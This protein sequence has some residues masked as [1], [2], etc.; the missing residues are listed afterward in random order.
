MAELELV[1]IMACVPTWIK[2]VTTHDSMHVS[3]VSL[4]VL[5]RKTTV[6]DAFTEKPIG[7]Y[8]IKWTLYFWSYSWVKVLSV[9][10]VACSADSFKYRS[11]QKSPNTPKSRSGSFVHS[12][13]ACTSSGMF[14]DPTFRQLH[15][16]FSVWFCLWSLFSL[17]PPLFFNSASPG[18]RTVV[19]L[20]ALSEV[21]LGR[22][23]S[24]VEEK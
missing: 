1:C 7:S 13:T 14:S 4:C 16:F 9:W 6:N 23:A 2:A 24:E 17:T 20:L 10:F 8:L 15:I 19:R 3:S 21:S 11:L 5:L 18:G 12:E 22:T